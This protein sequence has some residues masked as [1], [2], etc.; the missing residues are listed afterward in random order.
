MASGWAGGRE[1]EALFP[2]ETAGVP[3]PIIHP[4]SLRVCIDIYPHSRCGS[5]SGGPYRTRPIR[6]YLKFVEREFRR[7]GWRWWVR[8]SA[9]LVG[10]EFRVDI[11]AVRETIRERELSLLLEKLI[12]RER[13]MIRGY[14]AFLGGR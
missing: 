14:W 5:G 11:E 1:R 7:R 2:A 8:W 10:P 6:L 9:K 4:H 13:M 3:T 12:L